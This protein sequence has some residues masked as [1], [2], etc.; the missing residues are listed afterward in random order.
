VPLS[1]AFTLIELLIVIAII[2][3]LIGILLPALGHARQLGLTTACASN[4]RELGQC[5]VLYAQD[6]KEKIWHADK[7]LRFDSSPTRKT[8]GLLYNYVTRADKVIECPKNKRQ[9]TDGKTGPNIFG[10]TTPLDTDYTMVANTHGA[11]LSTATFAG[12]LTKPL[13]FGSEPLALPADSAALTLFRVLPIYLE[14]STPILN[15]VFIDARWLNN[16]QIT[17]RHQKGG[18]IVFLDTHVELLKAP[19][20][21]DEFAEEEADLQAV[22]CYFRLG[23]EW[24]Q[25]TGWLRP[26]G[27]VNSPE[28]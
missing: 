26:Y 13:P 11:R 22:D 4:M 17:W 18:N 14:E 10:G 12:Y 24:S 2:A 3:I 21:P 19:A 8:P 1:R 25:N 23:K 27:W 20:G 5:T 28:P 7:W 16:D 6:F 9:R 15:Q